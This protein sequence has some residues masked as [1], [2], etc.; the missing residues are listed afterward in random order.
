MAWKLPRKLVM[1]CA[2]RVVAHAT[3][4]V[5]GD[6]IV[7]ELTAMDAIKRWEKDS[8]EVESRPDIF[9]IQMHGETEKIQPMPKFD[10]RQIVIALEPGRGWIAQERARKRHMLVVAFGCLAGAALLLALWI[11]R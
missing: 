4:G 7:P 11:G 5:Y 6:Q 1:W 9:H 3:T 2:V 10:P 8:R